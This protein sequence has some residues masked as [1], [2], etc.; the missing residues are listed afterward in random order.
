MLLNGDYGT[1]H[2]E[3][4]A[5]RGGGKEEKK[6]SVWVRPYLTRRASKGHYHN[7][8]R[9]LAEED[10]DLYRNFMRLD[11]CLFL[12]IVERVRPLINPLHVSAR[13][14]SKFSQHIVHMC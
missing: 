1:Q 7:L 5:R 10:P 4:A 6:R 3:E 11:Q 13:C 2:L 14:M 9:E 8:M 12:E